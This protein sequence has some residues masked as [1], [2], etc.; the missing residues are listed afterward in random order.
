MLRVRSYI[1]VFWLSRSIEPF[2]I[3]N[4]I[5]MIVSVTVRDYYC[6]RISWKTNHSTGSATHRR[7]LVIFYARF[8]EHPINRHT[9]L[10]AR[11]LRETLTQTCGRMRARYVKP[12]GIHSYCHSKRMTRLCVG[13]NARHCACA[14][15][16]IV[17]GSNKEET[18]NNT[19]YSL[20]DFNRRYIW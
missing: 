4:L 12:S 19:N 3:P 5:S 17:F 9:Y 11:N 13:V 18:S 1:P 8:F 7:C 15:T 14:R 10:Y 2:Q 16:P 20:R 6:F